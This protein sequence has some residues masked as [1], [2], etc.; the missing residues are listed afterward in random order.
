MLF[1]V[2]PRFYANAGLNPKFVSLKSVKINELDLVLK[3]DEE[4]VSRS[5]YPNKDYLVAC[6]NKGKK[7]VDGILVDIGK[8]REVTVITTWS[9]FSTEVVHEVKYFIIGDDLGFA[10]TAPMRHV[11]VSHPEEIRDFISKQNHIAPTMSFKPETYFFQS[12]TDRIVKDA[13]GCISE[14][15]SIVYVPTLTEHEFYNNKLS[16]NS[17]L[18]K[19]EDVFIKVAKEEKE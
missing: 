14:L 11:F 2:I 1:H 9:Y 7:A 16:G 6:K 12:W 13:K 18:P 4:V 5:P 10:T 8:L 19:F 17:R 3:C 15:S